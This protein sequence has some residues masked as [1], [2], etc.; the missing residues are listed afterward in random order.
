MKTIT[1]FK[2][3][4]EIDSLP[5]YMIPY[6]FN[7]HSI[8]HTITSYTTRPANTVIIFETKYPERNII[9][10]YPDSKEVKPYKYVTFNIDGLH[11]D[12]LQNEGQNLG[13]IVYCI[14]FLIKN[15]PDII[16]TILQ[17]MPTHLY[18]DRDVVRRIANAIPNDETLKS[19]AKKVIR[20]KHAIIEQYKVQNSSIMDVYDETFGQ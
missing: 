2:E 1:L 5:D 19:I 8:E 17:A 18:L 4:T 15:M 6:D 11:L 12:D 7:L 16:I 20:E 3:D 9:K 13:D 14:E 10:Q